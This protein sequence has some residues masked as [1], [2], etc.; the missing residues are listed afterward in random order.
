MLLHIKRDYWHILEYSSRQ[1]EEYSSSSNSDEHLNE[2][3]DWSLKDTKLKKEEDEKII[4]QQESEDE[5][6]KAVV[7]VEQKGTSVPT[8]PAPALKKRSIIK[9]AHV[10]NSTM[11]KPEKQKAAGPSKNTKLRKTHDRDK[12]ISEKDQNAVVSHAHQAPTQHGQLSSMSTITMDKVPEET[13]SGPKPNGSTHGDR[14]V[15][16]EEMST[17]SEKGGG[18]NMFELFRTNDGEEYTVYIRE[19]GKRFYVDF[20]E[21][22]RRDIRSLT[23]Q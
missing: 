10:S 1:I 21:Q 11:R 9:K 14:R 16:V 8:Q 3:K 6:A 23:I 17:V 5:E 18:S 20:E 19:D 22:V 13:G 15:G 7:E 12:K 4:T 2:N